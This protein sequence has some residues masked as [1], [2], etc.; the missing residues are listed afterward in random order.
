MTILGNL[1]KCSKRFIS[2][3]IFTNWRHD[4]N[5]QLGCFSKCIIRCLGRNKQLNKNEIK[6]Y[7]CSNV[8]IATLDHRLD[9]NCQLSCYK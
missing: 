4:L 7:K 8:L 5:P 6:R 2:K 9:M 3:I 1:S